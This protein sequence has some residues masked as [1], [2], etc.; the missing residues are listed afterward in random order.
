MT[1]NKGSYRV[2]RDDE[3]V[4]YLLYTLA[5]AGEGPCVFVTRWEMYKES[6]F[7]YYLIT[8]QSSKLAA[9]VISVKP[10]E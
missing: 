2:K 4:I 3:A 6:Q 8:E 5:A 1:S 9:S 10:S 7:R